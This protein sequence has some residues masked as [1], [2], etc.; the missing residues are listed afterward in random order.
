MAL[1]REHP[2]VVAAQYDTDA[3]ISA[4]KIARA[5]LYPPS[6]CRSISRVQTDQTLG[7]NQTDSASVIAQANVPIYD[8]GLAPSQTR[9][10]K[11]GVSQARLQLARAQAQTDSAVAAA[12]VTNEGARIS[13]SAGEAEVKAA[14][15]ALSG[16]QKE[17]QAG[18]RTTLD[19]LNAQQD[20]TSARAR[21]IQAQRD[22]VVASYTLLGAVGRL[23][24]Q[25]PRPAY[26]G[27]QSGSSLPSG[28]RCLA[29]PAHAV[30]AVIRRAHTRRLRRSAAGLAPQ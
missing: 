16:V 12:W 6:A 23:D 30:G 22:R 11:E 27:L 19:V 24:A 14:A 20:L 10:A 7:A 4:V 15:V 9:Q 17:A 26:A 18:Q 5:G 29:R 3:A 21:L 28:A 1:R 25:A 8:G 2:A 13:V